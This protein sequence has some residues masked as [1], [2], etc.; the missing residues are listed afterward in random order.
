MATFNVSEETHLMV[1][2]KW[3]EL[4]NRGIKIR[5]SEVVEKAIKKGLEH[6]E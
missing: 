4:R 1:L 3:T 5:L 6:Y 2:N